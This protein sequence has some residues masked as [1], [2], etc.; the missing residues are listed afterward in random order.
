MWMFEHTERGRGSAEAVWKVWTDV[1]DWPAWDEGVEA[2]RIDGPFAAG[3]AGELTPRGGGPLAFT[4]VDA[5]PCEGFADETTIPGAVLRFEHE[6][7]FEGEGRVAVT[8]RVMI[9]GPEAEKVAAAMGPMFE[10]GMPG[11][12]AG[13]VRVA[14]SLSVA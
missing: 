2:A 13:V 3:T 11:A 9:E 7:V 4:I 14:G 8:H 10:T 5:R 6:V 12:V 1:E